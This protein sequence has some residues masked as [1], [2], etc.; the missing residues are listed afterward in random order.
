MTRSR[1]MWLAMAIAVGLL[2]YVVLFIDA[3]TGNPMAPNPGYA[4]LGVASYLIPTAIAA[5]KRKRNAWAIGALNVCLGWTVVGW[6][7]ALVWALS[8]Q[9]IDEKKPATA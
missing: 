6:V 9:A 7:A 5:A 1:G 3:A 4:A 2:T 8:V